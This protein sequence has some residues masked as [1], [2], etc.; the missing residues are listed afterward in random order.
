MAGQFVK[1]DPTGDFDTDTGGVNRSLTAAEQ[2]MAE[3]AQPSPGGLTYAAG[4]RRA[5]QATSVAEL[6]AVNADLGVALSP[7]ELLVLR[8]AERQAVA[9]EATYNLLAQLVNGLT[10]NPMVAAMMGGQ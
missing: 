8:L 10:A 3:T 5:Q 1:N 2:A 9:A 7:S 4:Y 6:V